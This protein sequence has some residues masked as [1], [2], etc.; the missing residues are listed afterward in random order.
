MN[1]KLGMIA[2][3]ITLGSVISFAV[4]MFAGSDTG[5][6]VFSLGISWGFVPMI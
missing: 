4:A 1:R 2:A 3:I 6:Y 5:S